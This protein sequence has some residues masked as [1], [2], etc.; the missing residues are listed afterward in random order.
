MKTAL[1]TLLFILLSACSKT[2]NSRTLEVTRAS[3]ASEDFQGGVLIKMTNLSTGVSSVIELTKSPFNVIIPDGKFKFD[4]VAY[5]G[6]SAWGGNTS[7]GS[8]TIE[9]LSTTTDI[10]LNLSND[11]APAPYP[12]LVSL[13][14]S[15]WDTAVWDQANWAP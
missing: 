3:L 1:I 7:C 8:T 15:N 6:P 11:C 4:M 10:D 9:L 2:P 14:I 12:A 13:K 5:L